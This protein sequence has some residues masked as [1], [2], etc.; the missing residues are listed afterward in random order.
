MSH[1][2]H[3]A[4]LTTYIS[5]PKETFDQFNVNVFGILNVARAVLP[6]MRQQRSGV[7]AMFGSLVS[8]HGYAAAGIYCSTKWAI[9]GL[10]ESLRPVVHGAETTGLR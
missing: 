8:W 4:S 5:S 2:T 6:Y 7:I 1:S 10:A 9:S 3:A